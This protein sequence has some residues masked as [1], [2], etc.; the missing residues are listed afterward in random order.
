MTAMNQAKSLDIRQ[1]LT[2]HI[3][4]V[5]HTMLSLDAIPQPKGPLPN[6]G[7]RITGSVGFGG[8]RVNGAMYV[9]LSI[10]LAEELACAMLKSAAPQISDTEINDVVGE[11]TN[12]LTGQFKSS[13]SDAGAGCA[14]STPAIIR[15][16]SY[17][18]EPSPG[19]RRELLLFHCRAKPMAVEVH[20]KFN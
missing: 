17:Q 18:I 13:L 5:F 14:M 2:G 6:F 1:L 9:H 10:G 3:A 12:I 16:L 7:E 20:I 11:I 15:G 4:D 19:V 8:D